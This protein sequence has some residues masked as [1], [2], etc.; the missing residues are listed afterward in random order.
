M[1]ELAPLAALAD[2]LG[3]ALLGVAPVEP[4]GHGWFA[5]HVERLNAWL[6]SGRHADMEWIA[7]RLEDRVVPER[8]LPNVQSALVFWLDHRTPALARPPGPRGRVAAYAW[9]RDYHNIARKNLRKLRIWLNGRYPGIRVY[10]SVDTGAVLERAFGERAGVGWIGKSTML[11]SQQRGTFGSL[12]VMFTDRAF[13]AAPAAHPGRC[14]TCTACIDQCPTQ[15]LGPEG[16]DARRCISFWTIEHRGVVPAEVRPWLGE[17]VFGCDICQDVCPW[18]RDV[19]RARAEVWQPAVDRAWP[20][21]TEWI[22]TPSE[23]LDARLEGSPLRRARGDGLR[24]NALIAVGNLRMQAARGA[25][26]L[27]LGDPDP[28][29]RATAVWAARCLGVE[30]MAAW[31]ACDPDAQVRA[32]AFTPLPPWPV[33]GTTQPATEEAS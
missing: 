30:G 6:A 1:S 3:F 5:P 32:E 24:R 22:V 4:K 28:M 26:L 23:V 18:N 31:A 14:G 9:G 16:L 12:A 19:P 11:I 7:E 20:D 13:E 10:L 33:S 29:L 27:A 2:R 8:L 25:V 21:L 17:W 15:A